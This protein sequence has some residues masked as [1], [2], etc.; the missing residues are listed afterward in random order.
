MTKYITLTRG[1]KALVDDQNYE[2]LKKHKWSAQPG[3]QTWY[4][5]RSKYNPNTG[6]TTTIKMHH[7]V[8]GN[9]PAGKVVDHINGN[10]LDNRRAKSP[11]RNP[12]KTNSNNVPKS[13]SIL[14]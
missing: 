7:A 14:I 6:K 9:P 13:V 3:R 12:P 11:N 4:A 2:R 1:K 10:G 5:L 8:A